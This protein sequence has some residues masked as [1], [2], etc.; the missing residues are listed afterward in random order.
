[1]IPFKG[2]R[3]CQRCEGEIVFGGIVMLP[4]SENVQHLCLKCAVEEAKAY[5]KE[6]GLETDNVQFIRLDYPEDPYG[7]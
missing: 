7:R 5:N 1:M 3:L 4:N 6:H 2:K